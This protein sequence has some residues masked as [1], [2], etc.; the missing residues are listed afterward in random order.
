[1]E[2]L[3][4]T[5]ARKQDGDVNTQVANLSIGPFSSF[6]HDL[7]LGKM[8][9]MDSYDGLHRCQYLIQL[10][11]CSGNVIAPFMTQ[12]FKSAI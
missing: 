5:I 12:Y 10:I 7:M 6:Y 8:K 11:Y 4:F 1:M 2:K 3:F 9:E